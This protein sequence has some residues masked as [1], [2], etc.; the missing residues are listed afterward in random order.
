MCPFS[1]S[2]MYKLHKHDSKFVNKNGTVFEFCYFSVDHKNIS[3][4]LSVYF[5]YNRFIKMFIH[6]F[7]TKK[8]TPEAMHCYK[9]TSQSH[10]NKQ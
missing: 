5:D 4:H 3:I 10:T 2:F 6:I 8:L 9:K 7:L 1:V